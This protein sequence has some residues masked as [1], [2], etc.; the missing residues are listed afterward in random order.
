M[1]IYKDVSEAL[2]K[3]ITEQVATNFDT[4]YGYIFPIWSTLVV[5]YL[6]I[7][8][9]AIIYGQK[10]MLIS[11]FIQHLLVISVV[12]VFMGA[13]SMYV[14]EIVPFVMKSGEQIAAGLT[15]S[16]GGN[17]IDAMINQI[18]NLGELIQSDY[19]DK[20]GFSI[21]GTLIFAVKMILLMASGG[22]FVL[23]AASYLIMAKMMVGILLSL[24]GIFIAFAVF[25]AT[26]QMFT[27]WVGSCFNYIFLNIGYAILFSIM[28]KYLNEY[29]GK[30]TIEIQS[31][32][33]EVFSIALVFGI[34]IF[35][36]QQVATLMSILTGG[37]GINGLV[38]AVN[39]FA[40]TAA[41]ATGL[42]KAANVGAGLAGKG[43]SMAGRGAMNMASSGLRSL[44]NK[45]KVKGG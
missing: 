27:A 18:I 20:S 23:Y 42:S 3:L 15:G 2:S 16:E 21:S 11:E 41:Q 38:G 44:M 26:R 33:W 6:V 19:A 24:G 14:T 31:N 34:G 8:A 22:L 36:L 10:E 7:E 35:L 5:I 30:N 12:T 1:E 25:P 43:A 37:V 32:V 17:S 29:I 9:W 40:K 28:I 39:G 13:S 45:G 4:L